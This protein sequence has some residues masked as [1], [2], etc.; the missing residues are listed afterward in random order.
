MFEWKAITEGGGLNLMLVGM[1]VVFTALLI[2][3]FMMKGLKRVL[4]LKHA[5]RMKKQAEAPPPV[6][7]GSGSEEIS[8][9][10]IAAIALTMILEDE[11]IHDEESLVLT[12]RS[13]PKSY[14][15]WWM[16]GLSKPWKS[17]LHRR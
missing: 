17:W 11:Q 5:S 3:M 2:L 4:N 6:A 13:L 12:L 10:V 16:Q 8:G 7:A 14:S 1:L 9:I 15:T